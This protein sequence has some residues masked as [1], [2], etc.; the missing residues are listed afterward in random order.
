MRWSD[1]RW[2]EV[3]WVS[4]R[5]HA[6]TD[7]HT[8][9][10]PQPITTLTGTV[11][12]CAHRFL[13][14]TTTSVTAP[15]PFSPQPVVVIARPLPSEKLIWD[16]AKKIHS[17]NSYKKVLV[18]LGLNLD[19]NGKYL[20]STGDDYRAVHRAVKTLQRRT[21]NKLL[22]ETAQRRHTGQTKTKKTNQLVLILN[23][24]Q[25]ISNVLNDTNL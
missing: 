5:A 2:S 14:N 16:A 7:T 24:Q 4:A 22:K 25:V 1:V 8:P 6:H 23:R 17:G 10:I 15:R 9:P 21:R 12:P 19:N 11:T 20:L 18:E 13:Q 3:R